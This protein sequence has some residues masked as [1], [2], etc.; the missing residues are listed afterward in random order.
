MLTAPFS[1]P[2]LRES[3][4]AVP[5]LAR[6]AAT[7]V[8]ATQN[9]QIIR[10]LEKGG[11]RTL[12]YGG[13]AIFYHV[14]MSEYAGLLTMLAD[15]AGSET[16]VVPSIGPAY[17]LAMDQVE[18]LRDFEFPDRDVV[19]VARRGGSTGDRDERAKV[20]R[21]TGQADCVVF[22]VRPVGSIR[23]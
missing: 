2:Q 13:N 8:C 18:V 23:I 21:Q 4:I 19:A 12:L 15:T 6:D 7:N 5:P 9:K 17:G 11:I 16:V 14:R 3:V 10:Y 20:S 22:E 1:V